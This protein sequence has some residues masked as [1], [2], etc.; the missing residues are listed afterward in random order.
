MFERKAITT[1]RDTTKSRHS[2]EAMGNLPRHGRLLFRFLRV[3]KACQPERGNKNAKNSL[4]VMAYHKLSNQAHGGPQFISAE[5]Q[6]FAN[7]WEFKHS[8]I[9]V[10]FAIERKK[11][12]QQTAV[13]IV[14][15]ILK[16]SD[17]PLTAVFEWRNM[18]KSIAVQCNG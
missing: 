5:L 14:K 16:K 15:N 12:N 11:Q 6:A 4:H 17:N 8:I 9:T 10:S 3:H 18:P 1:E 2:L 13:K 7:N